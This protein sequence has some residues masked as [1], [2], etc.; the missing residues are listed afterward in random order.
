MGSVAA[1]A[2]TVLDQYFELEV[3]P[4]GASPAALEELYALRFAIF[5]DE[6]GS[7]PPSITPTAS[8]TT[9]T[10]RVPRTFRPA[11]PSAG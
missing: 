1:E 8:S 6:C 4:P 3:F 5:C 7:C 11:M 2:L 10:T 9:A